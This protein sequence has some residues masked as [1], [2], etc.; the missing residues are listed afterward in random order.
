MYALFPWKKK[1]QD[2]IFLTINNEQSC[3]CF[4]YYNESNLTHLSTIQ[5][6]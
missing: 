3:T 4:R 1:N 5:I 2:S 6:R